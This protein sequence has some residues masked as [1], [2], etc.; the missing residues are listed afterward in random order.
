MRIGIIGMGYV[1][2]AV[3]WTHQSVDIIVHDP[4]LK[5][6]T[7]LDQ[8]NTCDAIYVCVPSPCVDPTLEDGRCDSGI[9]EQTLKELLFAVT[10]KQI[11]IICKTTAPPSVYA[12]LQEEYPNIVYVPEF[13]T[14]KNNLTDYAN[15]DHVII[16]GHYD[17]CVKVRKIIQL[18]LPLDLEKFTI[19]D[20]KTAALFKYMMNSYLAT[21]VTFMN[22]FAQLAKHEGVEWGD[23]QYLASQDSRI[24]TTHMAVPGDNGEYGWGGGCFPKDIAAIITEAIDLGLEFELMQKIETINKT[25]RLQRIKNERPVGRKISS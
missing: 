1:G 20:I 16:G 19:V 23:I 9:L 11:P 17:W 8:F 21:K 15:T 4:K 24:G 18:G 12:R 7:S 5:T 13:L 2:S 14:A 25:H 10:N 22:E 6:S 3:A